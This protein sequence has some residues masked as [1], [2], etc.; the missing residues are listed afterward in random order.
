MA[1]LPAALYLASVV[2]LFFY[3]LTDEKLRSTVPPVTELPAE[4]A[5]MA[6][7]P[8]PGRS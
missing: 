2:P 6:L 3:D 5:D 1:V 8:A 7:R 4:S